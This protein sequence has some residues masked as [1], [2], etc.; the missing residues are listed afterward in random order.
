MRCY[1]CTCTKDN[2][3]CVCLSAVTCHA[4][5]TEWLTQNAH[6]LATAGGERLYHPA[7]GATM[8]SMS[9]IVS[10]SPRTLTLSATSPSSRRCGTASSCPVTALGWS[11]FTSTAICEYMHN[12]FSAPIRVRAS[13]SCLCAC[14]GRGYV[15]RVFSPAL[16]SISTTCDV[17]AAL[18]GSRRSQAATP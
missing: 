5:Q 14:S 17:A 7:A 13:R 11:D 1:I 6:H 9:M 15:W 12:A 16:T 2:I 18:R 3:P 4:A 8:A 10:R